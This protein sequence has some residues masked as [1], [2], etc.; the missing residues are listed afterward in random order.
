MRWAWPLLGLLL[1]CDYQELE[2]SRCW[3]DC[4]GTT[5]ADA[6]D[7]EDDLGLSLVIDWVTPHSVALAW[8]NAAPS[9]V[10]RYELTI[11]GVTWDRTWDPQLAAR[12]TTQ[13]TVLGLSPGANQEALLRG[14]RS[15]G[16]SVIIARGN[17]DTPPEP[18]GAVVLYAEGEAPPRTGF[19]LNGPPTTHAG[20]GAL[21]FDADAVGQGDAPSLTGLSTNVAGLI[22]ARDRAYLELW[23]RVLPDGRGV[24]PLTTRLVAGGLGYDCDRALAP[25]QPG[26][27]RVQVPLRVHQRE[28][29]NDLDLSATSVTG[30]ALA[31]TWP[32]GSTIVIDDLQLRY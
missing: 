7:T 21:W 20:T 6:G 24:V 15:G 14:I 18:G 31:A 1:A 2:L 28:G 5:T 10:E 3:P 19:L 11:G 25:T 22:A 17:F 8:P 26:W 27:H 32:A 4:G 9:D 13:T 23:I 16:G 29:G 12:G 30:F